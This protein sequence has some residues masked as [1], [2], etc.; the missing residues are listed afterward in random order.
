MSDVS[1]DGVKSVT[2]NSGSESRG[3]PEGGG[4]DVRRMGCGE[5]GRR[6]GWHMG[7]MRRM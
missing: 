2:G 5:D 6:G 3:K 7:K 4:W 1:P